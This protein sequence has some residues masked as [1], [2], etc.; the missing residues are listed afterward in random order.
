MGSNVEVGEQ[1]PEVGGCTS[2]VF[3]SC[4]TIGPIQSAS[5]YVVLQQACSQ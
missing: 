1:A 4:V 2:P 3:G 5:R